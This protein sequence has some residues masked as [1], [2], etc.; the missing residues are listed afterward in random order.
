M[1]M[2]HS[3]CGYETVTRVARLNTQARC[4]SETRDSFTAKCTRRA[5][6]PCVRGTQS[7]LLGVFLHRFARLKRRQAAGLQHL[8]QARV[9]LA[10]DGLVLS[11]GHVADERVVPHI[12][13]V[14]VSV[15]VHGPL[16]TREI[17][18]PRAHVLG[19]Q[20]ARLV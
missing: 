13:R 6:E 16:E 7:G 1:R 2:L 10:A 19:L 12:R 5:G 9:L 17:R 15:D 20:G 14:A 3:C 18:V 4:W 11:E 8:L